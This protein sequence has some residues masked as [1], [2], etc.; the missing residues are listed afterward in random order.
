MQVTETVSEGLKREYKVVWPFSEIE[1]RAGEKL[2]EVAREIN[3][4]GFRPGKVPV[5]V[6]QRRF[7][8]DLRNDIMLQLIDEGCKIDACRQ[9]P[10]AIRRTHAEGHELR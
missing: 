5:S 2:R 6:V 1:E 7:G 4:P 8:A 3:L 10:A 9:G